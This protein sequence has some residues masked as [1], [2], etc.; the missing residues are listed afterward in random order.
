MK[1]F[2][3]SLLL[4]LMVMGLTLTGCGTTGNEITNQENGIDQ[5]EV[6][7]SEDVH[8]LG[9]IEISE[10]E[11]NAFPKEMSTYGA[12]KE[13]LPAEINLTN[14]FPKPGNQGAQG[15]CVGWATAYALKTYLEKVD[16]DWNQNLSEHQFSPA[17]VYNQINGG[18][19]QGS[20]ISDA[21]DLI[22]KQGV[23]SLKT[24]PYN[25][26]NFTKQPDKK[27]KDE[28][29]KYK[30]KNWST[31]KAGDI[32]DFKEKL[33]NKRPIV[34]GIPVHSDFDKLNKDNP[35]YDNTNGESRG[36][37]A[38]CLIGYDDS[39]K[40]FKLI[41]SWGTKWGLEGYG[42]ISYNLIKDL[43]IQ[44]YVMADNV[45]KK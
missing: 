21:L 2:Y 29:A 16:F 44:G 6:N 13:A 24:M 4:L 28:A 35:I 25:A 5:T 22:V 40:A 42:F 26:N 7:G 8:A 31:L 15:S 1:R 45:H 23:C 12:T 33:A 9:L 27:Q 39:K 41:N 43:K 20:K 11:Y 10:K 36:G 17:Y 37:H 19:D 3:L 34:V 30:S 32:A 38:I 18:K 14:K